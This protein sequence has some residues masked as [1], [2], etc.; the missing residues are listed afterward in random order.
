MVKTSLEFEVKSVRHDSQG[1]FILLK[2]TVQDEKFVSE[3]I[4][5]LT[6]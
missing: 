1:W 2:A 5:F 4:Y 3:Q 6:K